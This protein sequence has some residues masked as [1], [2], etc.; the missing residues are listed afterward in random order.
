MAGQF[1]DNFIMTEDGENFEM[2]QTTKGDPGEGVPTGGTAGQVLKKVS[3][4]DYDTEWADN[5]AGDVGYDSEET[6]QSGTVG[7]TLNDLSRHLSDVEDDLNRSIILS[8]DDYLNIGIALSDG[9]FGTRTDTRYT[10]KT[11]EG[12]HSITFTTVEWSTPILV[13]YNATGGVVSYIDGARNGKQT[14][15]ESIPTGAVKYAVNCQLSN[16]SELSITEHYKSVDYLLTLVNSKQDSSAIINVDVSFRKYGKYNSDGSFTATITSVYNIRRNCE[17][18]SKL[19]INSAYWS[20]PKLVYFDANG[21]LLQAVNGNIGDNI[22][23]SYVPDGAVEYAVN[24]VT[25]SALIGKFA[26]QETVDISKYLTRVDHE[27]NALQPEYGSLFLPDWIPGVV[28]LPSYIYLE[29]IIKNGWLKD[30]EINTEQN[31]LGQVFWG[32]RPEMYKII[33]ASP[34]VTAIQISL[35]DKFKDIQTATVERRVVSADTAGTAKIMIIGDSKSESRTPWEALNLL[36]SNDQNMSI[37]FVGTNRG[38]AFP[39]EAYSG[40]NVINVCDDEYISG[41]IPNIFYDASVTTA[42]GHH[43][44]FSKGVQT[45]GEAP[46]IVFIDHGANQ[47][48]QNWSIIKGCYDDMIESIH[49]YDSNIKIVIVLQEGSGALANTAGNHLKG[50]LYNRAGAS[51]DKMLSY[52]KG[53]ESEKVFIQPQ[54]LCVDLYRDYPICSLPT[55]DGASG[56]M[57]FC[58]DQTHPGLNTATWN[59]SSAYAW[60]A[61]VNRNGKGYGCKKANTNVDPETDDGTYWAECKNLGDGY[62]K[63]GLMYYCM[64]KYLMTV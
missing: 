43:F 60:G 41:T 37:T 17:A 29:N 39:R 28:G 47:F 31:D 1:C 52:F 19:V 15:T 38:D 32:Y 64:L 49:N 26:I 61:W 18:V 46:D 58:M 13:F 20:T 40:K 50:W 33:P 53:R 16:I 10:M 25:D 55:F 62:R 35:A 45:L 5:D 51:E 63:K 59:A 36:L 57:E 3:D 9:T 30:Y 23:E 56:E 8:V 14:R 22:T 44:N 2:T 4:D 54:Y 24:E 7:K 42:N 21:N 27:I 34:E 12:L 11:C 6:Y 48:W